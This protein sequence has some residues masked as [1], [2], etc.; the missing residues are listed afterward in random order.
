MAQNEYV[1]TYYIG[2]TTLH[3][4]APPSMPEE[5]KLKIYNRYMEVARETYRDCAEKN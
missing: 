4:V 1:V 5:E 3:V 2:N